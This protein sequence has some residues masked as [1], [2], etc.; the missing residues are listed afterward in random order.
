MGKQV[1]VRCGTSYVIYVLHYTMDRLCKLE[2]IM[3]G[4]IRYKI[5]L[6]FDELHCIEAARKHEGQLLFIKRKKTVNT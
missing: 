5:F 1:S 4:F 3:G 6:V 2:D